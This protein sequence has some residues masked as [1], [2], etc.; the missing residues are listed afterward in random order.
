VVVLRRVVSCSCADPAVALEPVVPDV[1]VVCAVAAATLPN[2]RAMATPTA[3]VVMN[4][5]V[6]G[7]SLLDAALWAGASRV[8]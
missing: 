5:R 7:G 1:P 3:R 8:V 6:I 2:V 4:R